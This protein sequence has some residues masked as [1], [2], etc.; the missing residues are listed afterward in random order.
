M[1]FSINVLI[2][3]VSI[4]KQQKVTCPYNNSFIIIEEWSL[5]HYYSMPEHLLL[6]H[7][8]WGSPVVNLGIGNGDSEDVNP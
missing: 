3:Q 8:T 5:S 4:L 7:V 2:Y 6:H 1:L